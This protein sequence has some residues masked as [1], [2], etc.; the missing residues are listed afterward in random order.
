MED[1]FIQFGF[2]PSY[3]IGFGWE[4]FHPLNK[5]IP[6]LYTENYKFLPINT[7]LRDNEGTFSQ[8]FIKLCKKSLGSAVT[9][10]LGK[11]VQIINGIVEGQFQVLPNK[12]R[13]N[14]TKTIINLV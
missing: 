12:G 13:T 7:I 4:F 1:N 8:E 5:E 3:I 11:K 14:K 6:V 10:A 2:E 9:F